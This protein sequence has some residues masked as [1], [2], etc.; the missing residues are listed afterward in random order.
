MYEQKALTDQVRI[1]HRDKS[2]SDNVL[3]ERGSIGVLYLN[4]KSDM[5]TTVYYFVTYNST[6]LLELA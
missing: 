5:S 3:S 4:F 6:T 1:L 2:E